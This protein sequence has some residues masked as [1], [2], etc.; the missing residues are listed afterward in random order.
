[1]RVLLFING[2]EESQK[3]IEDGFKYLLDLSKIST[4]EWFYYQD[5]A[6]K[7]STEKSMERMHEIALE[8]QPEVII[9]FHLGKFKIQKI[10]LDKLKNLNSNPYLVYDEGDMYGGWA[11]PITKQMKLIIKNVDAVSIRGLGKYYEDIRKIR[12][13]G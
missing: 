6:K 13:K 1:M 4:L 10:I 2:A 8:F 9:I 5:Y 11:K 7:F 12:I 3:G